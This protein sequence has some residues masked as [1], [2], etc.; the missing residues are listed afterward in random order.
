[1]NVQ[2]RA[3]EQRRA[4]N[5]LFNDRKLKLGTFCTNL[6]GGCTMSEADGMLDADW[7]STVTLA[8]LADEPGV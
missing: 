3:E 5:P 1:M 6:S 2:V 4:T 8:T 7:S